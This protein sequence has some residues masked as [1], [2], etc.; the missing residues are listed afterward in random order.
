MR[1]ERGSVLMLMPAAVLV[2][3]ALAGITVDSAIAFLGEREVSNA[4]HAAANDVAGLVDEAHFRVT[5]E[6]RIRCEDAPEVA[7]ASFAAR[8]PAWLRAG[9]VEVVACGGNQVAVAA[10]GEVDYLFS[11]AVPGGPDG[12][13]VTATATATAE[14]R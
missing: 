11:K 4:A 6:V 10:A 1:A 9:R 13:R 8:Q 7:A 2:L 3:V 12:A 5:G 14:I